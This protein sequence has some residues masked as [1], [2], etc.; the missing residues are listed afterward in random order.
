MA[1][2]RIESFDDAERVQRQNEARFEDVRGAIDELAMQTS[3]AD[4]E[5]SERFDRGLEELRQLI[6]ED[7]LRLRETEKL[8]KEQIAALFEKS[9]RIDAQMAKSEKRM[10]K[11]EKRMAKFGEQLA[12]A[13]AQRAK[14]EERAAKQAEERR[15]KAEERRVQAEERAEA[16]WAKSEAQRVKSEVQRAKAEERAAKQAEEQRVR[17]NAQFARTDAIIADTKK[18]IAITSRKLKA[19]GIGV[20]N[21]GNSRG[22]FIEHLAMPSIKRI[23]KEQLRAD[24][25]GSFRGGSKSKQVQIDAWATSDQE[26]AVYIF[27][28]KRK[29]RDDAI[30]Q[31]FLQIERLRALLPD[32][33]LS[34]IYPFI[35]AGVIS[36]ADEQKVWQAGVHLLKFGDG[37]FRLCEPP[38]GFMPESTRGVKVHAR[39]APCSHYLEWLSD[40]DKSNAAV[41]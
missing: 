19:V 15:V 29:F 8:H 31:V 30:K 20:G 3:G 33:A 26:D 40:I 17:L 32:Y 34:A 21:L 6:R 4:S 22:E 1:T 7:M 9:D 36:E 14:A 11:F 2:D 38:E 25:L 37:A 16:L 5:I 28:I 23:V 12:K 39:M 35:A 41:H 13:E 18:Q 24:F 10:A 27:E